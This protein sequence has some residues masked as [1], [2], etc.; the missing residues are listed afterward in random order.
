MIV[1]VL[2]CGGKGNRLR[3]YSKINI[4]KPLLKLRNKPLIE[5]AINAIQ[6]T[7]Q[8]IELYAAVSN[9]TQ[10]TR[11]F[12]RSRYFNDVKIIETTGTGFSNDYLHVLQ[13]FKHKE[14]EIKKNVNKKLC[15][16]GIHK[17]LFLPVDL[18]LI[19]TKTLK[20]V[21]NLE[22]N[23]PCVAIVVDKKMFIQNDFDPSPFTIKI[24]EIE[25]CYTG[26]S[27]IVFPK[28]K[29]NQKNEPLKEEPV[30]INNFELVF[31]INTLDDLK[32]TE[33]N[34]KPTEI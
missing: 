32:K 33:K 23:S 4:E 21:T 15:L 27:T 11:E 20:E 17:I 18:P 26:I 14:S 16:K 22:Q 7:N 10:R 29:G 9:N 13:F 6:K 30:I 8:D 34:Y 31:N 1:C 3:T 2:M 24:N 28:I 5:Y 19:S 25:Y 12:L